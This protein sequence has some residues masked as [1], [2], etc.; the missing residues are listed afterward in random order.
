VNVVRALYDNGY[1]LAETT[2]LIDRTS[3]KI[4]R[5]MTTGLS[6]SLSRQDW[7]FANKLSPEKFDEQIGSTIRRLGRFV[8][9][10]R[11]RAMFGQVE[12]S[13]D[14][15]RA[16]SEG[17]IILVSLGRK[18]ALVSPEDARTFAT[19]LL[20][21]LWTAAQE[22]RDKA[23]KPKP[24]YVYLDEFQRFIT[25]TMAEGLAEARGFGL[26]LTMAHQFPNQ[27]LSRGEHG[28][29]LFDEVMENAQSKVV[30]RLQNPENLRPLAH[31]LFTGV[32]DPDR[33]KNEIYA[34][35]VLD[36]RE[37][38]EESSTSSTSRSAGGG[39]SRG[40][41]KGS[42]KTTRVKDPGMSEDEAELAS[43]NEQ[44]TSSSGES[45]QWN[46]SD[47]ES[48]TTRTVHRPVLGKELSSIERVS[49]DE[50]LFRSLQSLFVQQDRHCAVRLVGQRAP[51]FL[52]TFDLKENRVSEKRRNEYIERR[53]RKSG[54][55]LTMADAKRRLAERERV[56]IDAA[57]GETV[58]DEAMTAK[59]RIVRA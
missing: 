29:R 2:Y 35:K 56:L 58:R 51:L 19:L 15:G 31:Q 27:L 54:F 32:I 43:W 14:L 25:P 33:I 55:F 22:N 45:E 4:R 37:E 57:T 23:K 41:S 5:H 17:Q 50:Q 36:Y 16:L 46:E 40:E 52:R 48:V 42:G 10:E 49:I 21:D 39:K 13:L 20:S 24:F 18:N 8:R 34:T 38:I 26:H 28:K 53:F 6:E 12:A 30:F 1:T 47:G 11:L 59:R 3:A 9:N 7:E 44:A